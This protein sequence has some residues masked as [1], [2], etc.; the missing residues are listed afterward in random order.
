MGELPLS[1]RSGP[2]PLEG[3]TVALTERPAGAELQDEVAAA[4]E[5]ARGACEELG[6]RVVE[7]RTPWA[8]DWHDLLIVLMADAWQLHSRFTD[9]NE[10]YRPAIAEFVELAS[11]FTDAQAYMGAQQ[12]RVEGTALWEEWFAANGV[13]AVLEPT[14]PIVPYERGPGYDRGHAG[15]PG[16]PMIA[17]TALWDMTGMPVVT[18]PAAWNVGIS[19]IAPRGREAPLTQIGIDLQEKA[20]PPAVCD[21]RP[22]TRV[23]PERAGPA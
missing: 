8:F 10:L 22:P 12:R 15:G 4:Y 19:L 20:L 5:H 14:L 18:L 23:E 3:V 1:A 17:L 2:K 11:T 16:D 7:L 13:D 21:L 9:K 6:A